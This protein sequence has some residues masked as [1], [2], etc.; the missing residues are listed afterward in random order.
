MRKL[1]FSSKGSFITDGPYK[2]FDKPRDQLRWAFIITASKSVPDITYIDKH[3]QRMKELNWQVEEIDLDGKS[4]DDLREFFK[5]KD[6]INMLGGNAFYLLKSMRESGFAEVLN[7]FMDRGGVYCGSS[8][9][10]YVACPTIE[11]ATW[12]MPQKFNHHGITDFTALNLVP[13][14]VVAHNTPE[15]EAMIKPKMDK[16]TYPVH[17]LTDIQAILVEGEKITLL[18]DP[19]LFSKDFGG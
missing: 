12:K 16:T 19:T 1:F 9:G 10:V 15:I 7:E 8:A 4:P 6:A 13:F 18:E 11:V 14:L 5:D 3:R 17:L 2:L